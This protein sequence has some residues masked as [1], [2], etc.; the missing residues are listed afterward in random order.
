MFDQDL[1][2]REI[3]LLIRKLEQAEAS[4]DKGTVSCLCEF[5]HTS[6]FEY[7]RCGKVELR[8][9]DL[10]R[11]AK[12]NLTVKKFEHLEEFCNKLVPR[13]FLKAYFNERIDDVEFAIYSDPPPIK[14]HHVKAVNSAV[15]AYLDVLNNV[16]QDIR[17]AYE[18]MW[19]EYRLSKRQVDS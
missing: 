14:T 16:R 6:L 19:K 18:H 9:E 2:D 1:E 8:Q 5:I 10:L 7:K 15:K 4:F 11:V 17:I 3:D 13:W 12:G